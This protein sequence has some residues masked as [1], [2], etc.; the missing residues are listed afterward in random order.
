MYT[1]FVVGCTRVLYIFYCDCVCLFFSWCVFSVVFY[2][3]GPVDGWYN[4]LMIGLFSV[5][6]GTTT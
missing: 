2:A 5:A 6:D 1:E 4:K 3:I